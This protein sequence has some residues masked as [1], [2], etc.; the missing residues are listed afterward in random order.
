MPHAHGTVLK[1]L[2]RLGKSPDACWEWLSVVNNNGVAE[3]Q[4]AGRKVPARRW[5]WEQL[6]GPIP[7]GYVIAQLCG[8][9]TCINPHHLKCTTFAEAARLG[10]NTTLSAGDATA[11]RAARRALVKDAKA[12]GKPYSLKALAKQL[13]AQHDVSIYTI[14]DV[15]R[16]DT[17]KAHTLH[18]TA[19]SPSHATLEPA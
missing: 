7:E 5:L 14:R 12:K 11:I 19:R 2:V 13:A 17:W 4:F 18:P 10:T 15:W 9:T 8:T 1:P 6:F 16:G 3:K